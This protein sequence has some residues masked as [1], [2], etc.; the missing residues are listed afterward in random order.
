VVELVTVNH[1]R[2]HIADVITRYKTPIIFTIIGLIAGPIVGVMLNDY[3][4]ITPKR[5]AG[6]LEDDKVSILERALNITKDTKSKA[7]VSEFN[8]LRE[9]FKQPIRKYRSFQQNFNWSKL[10]FGNNL[11]F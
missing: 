6:L 11:T 8:E 10:S 3:I 7:K 2:A 1:A 9:Q 5:L 4:T